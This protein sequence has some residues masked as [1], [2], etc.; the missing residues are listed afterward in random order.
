[1]AKEGGKIEQTDFT[2]SHEEAKSTIKT[3]YKKAWK[4]IT[5]TIITNTTA[6]IN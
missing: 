4:K 2:L 5:R 1:L 3:A 6:I